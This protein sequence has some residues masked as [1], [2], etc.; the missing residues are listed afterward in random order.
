[1]T[2]PVRVLIVDDDDLMRAGLRVV[3]SSDAAIEV[4]PGGW[5]R[6]GA[7]VGAVT[8]AKTAEVEV[9]VKHNDHR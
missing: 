4:I 3:L 5:V 1:M 8:C 7:I 9:V 6:R 2:A